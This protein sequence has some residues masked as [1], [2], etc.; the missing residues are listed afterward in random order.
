MK[1]TPALLVILLAVGLFLAGCAQPTQPAKPAEAAPS[2]PAIPSAGAPT[3]APKAEALPAASEPAVPTPAASAGKNLYRTE[4][5]Y[6]A[7]LTSFS[8]AEIKGTLDKSAPGILK[9]TLSIQ[10]LPRLHGLNVFE[11]TH[12]DRVDFDY[13]SA[14]LV[15]ESGKYPWV[16]VHDFNPF[17]AGE[18]TDEALINRASLPAG[19][20]FEKNFDKLAITVEANNPE[21]KPSGIIIYTAY[22]NHRDNPEN[23]VF[24]SNPNYPDYVDGAGTVEFDASTPDLNIK[25]GFTGLPRLEETDDPS[26]DGPASGLDTDYYALWLADSKEKHLPILLGKFNAEP[27]GAT[28]LM[29]TLKPAA[30]KNNDFHAYDRVYLS[31][32]V[33]GYD[34][35]KPSNKVALI[36]EIKKQGE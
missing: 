5:K 30:L 10:G 1:A 27:S 34:L 3:E 6:N 21:G 24:K 17:T 26:I 29:T 33:N 22:F 12:K 2:Q 25:A 32:E 14:W 18:T 28:P 35:K 16:H 19:S 13:Y 4:M 20:V 15:D 11:T 23:L 8:K 31:V 36:G 9:Q 7:L